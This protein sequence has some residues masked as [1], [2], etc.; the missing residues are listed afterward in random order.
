MTAAQELNA[1]Y[2]QVADHARISGGFGEVTAGAEGVTAAAEG[3]AEPATYRIS[4]AD[5]GLWISVGTEDRWLSESIEADLMNSGDDLEELFDDELVELGIE[6]LEFSF[7]HFRSD[8][9]EYVFRVRVPDTERD[10]ARVGAMLVAFE[11][12]F[13]ELGDMNAEDDG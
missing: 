13:R 2:Q 11:R 10:P 7:E 4:E 5:G 3:S 1:L 12:C 8:A 9:L 6:G